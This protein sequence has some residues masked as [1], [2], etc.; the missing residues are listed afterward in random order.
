MKSGLDWF[1]LDVTLD[2]KVQ[3]IEAEF[4]LKGFAIVVKLF[5]LIYGEQGYYCEWTNDVAM[6][7]S[8]KQGLGE[9]YAAV[10]EIVAASIKRGIFDQTLYE[11]YHILTSAG[12]QRRYFEAVSRRK[13]VKVERRYLLVEPTQNQIN[14]DIF[15]ENVSI[16]EKNAYISEQSRVEK[17]RVKKSKEIKANADA[18]AE[19]AGDDTELLIALRGFEAMRRAKKKP[20]TDKAKGML[21]NKLQTFPHSDW[22]AILNQSEFNCWQ[23]IYAL[24]GQKQPQKDTS[25]DLGEYEALTNTNP[26]YGGLA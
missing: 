2:T 18:F 17:S 5:Q 20:L 22:V 15:E 19:F 1:P 3:L 13:S 7:F 8:R 23:G 12:I 16:N 11:K 26:E 24:D 21:L 25:F 14:V 6:L 4:G 10:S 9:G